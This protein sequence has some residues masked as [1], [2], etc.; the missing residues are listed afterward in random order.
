MN[1]FEKAK[2]RFSGVPGD[3][4]RLLLKMKSNH[5][6]A[7]HYSL[8]AILLSCG[9]FQSLFDP[10]VTR[11]IKL[12]DTQLKAADKARGYPVINVSAIHKI[13]PRKEFNYFRML[14]DSHCWGIR[15][16]AIPPEGTSTLS[17]TRKAISDYTNRTVLLPTFPIRNC[18]NLDADSNVGN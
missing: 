12:I 4:V 11:M 15:C 5:H 1:A 14:E 7:R 13:L 18:H 3:A 6:D 10:V 2:H 16:L 17:S 8:G 9:D